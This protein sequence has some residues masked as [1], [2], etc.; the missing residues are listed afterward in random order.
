MTAGRSPFELVLGGL[1]GAAA[2]VLPMFFHAVG[3]GRMFLPMHLP[4]LVLGFLASVRVAVATGVLVPVVSYL[5]TGM[6]PAYPPVL[7]KMCVELGSMAAVASLAYRRA[8]WGLVPS[9][10]LAILTERAAYLALTIVVVEFF[11]LPGREISLVLLIASWPGMVLQLVVVPAVVPW[12]APRI[13]RME[14]IR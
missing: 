3:L 4:I 7:P 13:R 2:L 12:L 5:L 9:L 11:H 8:G 1:F 10:V 14:R 6:P